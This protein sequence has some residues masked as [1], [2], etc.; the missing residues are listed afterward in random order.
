MEGRRQLGLGMMWAEGLGSQGVNLEVMTDSGPVSGL[1][2]SAEDMSATVPGQGHT[3]D[4]VM[5]HL[6]C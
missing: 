6:D 2:T 5:G 1:V 3:Y 4:H